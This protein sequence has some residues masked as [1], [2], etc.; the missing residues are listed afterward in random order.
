MMVKR[1][2]FV[3]ETICCELLKYLE[4]HP[5]LLFYKNKMLGGGQGIL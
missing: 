5:S 4:Y 2:D 1:R 3:L